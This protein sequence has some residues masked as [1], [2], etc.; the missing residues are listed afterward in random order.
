MAFENIEQLMPDTTETRLAFE[1]AQ[2]TVA[3]CADAAW[4][5]ISSGDVLTASIS[6]VQEA[7]DDAWKACEPTLNAAGE[8]VR[9]GARN[10]AYLGGRFV[11]GVAD[12]GENAYVG[13]QSNIELLAEDEEAAVKTAQT[14]AVDDAANAWGDFMEADEQI[15]EI[16]DYVE[17]GGEIATEVALGAVAVTASAPAALA[18]GAVLV[19]DKM[20]KSLEA[21]AEDGEISQE[22]IVG[23]VVAGTVTAA[24]LLAGRGLNN[25]LASK[26]A[27]SGASS[28]I[29]D[30]AGK[31]IYE[32]D[33]LLP[34]NEF[35]I[36]GVKCATDDLGQL[37]R[38]GD[39]LVP[40]MSYEINGYKYVTDAMGRVES[41]E[42]FLQL[43]THEGRLTIKDTIQSIGKGFEELFDQ[44]GHLIAD[45][46]NG[47]NGLENI[48]AMGGEVNQKPMQQSSKNAPMLWL[49]ALKC[50]S[51]LS[52]FMR[53]GHSG[54][55]RL[56]SRTLLTAKRRLRLIEHCKG[57]VMSE[58]KMLQGIAS[59]LEET[60]PEDWSKVVFYAEYAEGAF[61]IEY[62]VAGSGKDDFVKC[63]DQKGV[64][65]ASLMKNF[66]AINK[67][68]EPERAALKPEKRWGSMTLILHSNGKFKVDYDYS[69]MTENAYAR[70]KAWKKKYL[71]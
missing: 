49:M 31:A 61:S 1:E 14:H 45:R 12:V 56:L 21:G 67:F 23:E 20:G 6:T 19:L 40:N 54:L 64:S 60:L 71:A 63:F 46:F 36:D 22:D 5:D 2:R 7:A 11:L 38:V 41:A 24:T 32:G 43:K 35:A 10:G 51:R 65:R 55:A 28:R 59:I 29:L 58:K 30:D 52:H 39:D 15:R 42:G 53:A 69:D 4:R 37:Y 3:D 26:A 34:N 13:V 8:T 57:N 9:D 47:S 27:E 50:F 70:K 68:I 33:R 66:M 18:A 44:R 62:Y 16:G 17:T 48:V 25:F